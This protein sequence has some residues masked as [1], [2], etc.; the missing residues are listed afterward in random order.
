M[1]DYPGLF[2]LLSIDPWCNAEPSFWSYSVILI[3]G[4]KKYHQ[5]LQCFTIVF[6][7]PCERGPFQKQCRVNTEHFRNAKEEMS[8]FCREML[9]FKRHFRE[10]MGLNCYSPDFFTRMCSFKCQMLDTASGVSL[11]PSSLFPVFMPSWSNYPFTNCKSCEDD[12]AVKGHFL[13]STVK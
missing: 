13:C 2:A 4:G 6:T 3:L 9:S 5:R 10:T 8:L 7:D 11:L 12:G 1:L